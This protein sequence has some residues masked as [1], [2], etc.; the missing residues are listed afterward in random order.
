MDQKQELVEFYSD[1]QQVRAKGS[2]KKAQLK[3]F[4]LTDMRG[5]VF[6][7]VSSPYHVTKDSKAVCWIEAPTKPKGDKA[8]EWKK[9]VL[10][11]AFWWVAQSSNPEEVNLKIHKSNFCGYQFPVLTNTR[12]LKKFDLLVAE[13]ETPAAK[14]ARTV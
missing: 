2:I 8:T 11:A 14:K 1:P 3:L 5:L 13:S 4:P 6:K 10:L 12:A 7:S 9:D